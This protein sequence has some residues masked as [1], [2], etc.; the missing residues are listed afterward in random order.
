MTSVERIHTSLFGR[1]EVFLS[2]IA[3]SA[4]LN[5]IGQGVGVKLTI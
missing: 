1:V 2:S 5:L 3:A 4:M